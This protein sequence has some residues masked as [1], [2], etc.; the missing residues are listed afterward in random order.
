MTENLAS[1]FR[2]PVLAALALL[3][4]SDA[5]GGPLRYGLSQ[6]GLLELSYAPILAATLVAAFYCVAQLCALRAD[7]VAI[8]IFVLSGIWLPYALMLGRPPLQVVFGYYTW[9][10]LFL[11]MVVVAVGGLAS[12]LRLVAA[13]WWVAVLG[14]FVSAL[15]W[16][17]WLGESYEIFGVRTQFARAWSA[18]GIQRLPGFSRAS[19]TAANQIALGCALLLAGQLG[20][21]PK[22]AIWLVSLA[23]VWLTTSKAPL[24]AVLLTPLFI[25]LTDRV[26]RWRDG[27]FGVRQ[28]V[29]AG[30]LSVAIALPVSALL[31]LRLPQSGHFGFLSLGSLGLRMADMWP[32]AFALLDPP[33]PRLVLGL[34]FGGIGAGQAYFDPAQYSAADNLFLFLYASFGLGALF[35][36]AAFLQGN[37]VLAELAPTLFRALAIAA[38]ALLVI[39]M[40]SNVVESVVPALLLGLLA[41]KALDPLASAGRV[42]RL[43]APDE[44]AG[45]AIVA[46]PVRV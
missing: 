37:R 8:A 19:F 4:A 26:G 35:F 42:G 17:P 12:A 24:I 13:I 34:G 30:L 40:M 3:L 23:A 36:L 1:S 21:A 28:V 16:L 7:A 44:A 2:M 10:P 43:S 25:V 20:M 45:P 33:W 22:V 32:R 38:A 41:G 6:L 14:V 18:F 39:G 15:V 11:G 46:A 27:G 9:M 31:G 5:L 29:L